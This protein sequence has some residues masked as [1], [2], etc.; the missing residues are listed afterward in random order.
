[1]KTLVV[2]AHPDDET[3]FLGNLIQSRK[4][5]KL[6]CVTDGNAEGRGQERAQELAQACKL[7]GVKDHRILG[8]R[9]QSSGR[10]AVQEIAEKIRA[11]GKFD[12]VYTHGILGEYGHVNH[13]DVSYATHLAFR[14]TRTKVFSVAYN[15]YAEKIIRPTE[16][17]LKIK[18]RIMTEVYFKETRRFLNVLP[19]T[20]AEG[21]SRVHWKEIEAMY[22]LLTQ[23]IEPPPKV[24]RFHSHLIAMVKSGEFE[25]N[26]QNFFKNYFGA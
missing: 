21:Y 12:E 13:Q 2:T 24:A 15:I 14:G 3:I 26:T 10:F 18:S 19:I 1:M 17:Q 4:G 8:Y 11:L 7:L 23:N 6:V 5:V 22:A 16:R 20:N 9:D 25:R